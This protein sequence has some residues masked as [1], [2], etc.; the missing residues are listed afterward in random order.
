MSDKKI[1]ILILGT[2][3]AQLIT[4][5]VTLSFLEFIVLKTLEYLQLFLVFRE[6]YQHLLEVATKLQ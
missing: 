3:V 1:G 5:G 4:I 6:Y 2:F